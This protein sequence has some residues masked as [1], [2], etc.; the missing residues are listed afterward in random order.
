MLSHL[1]ARRTLAGHR[2][3]AVL[4]GEAIAMAARRDRPLRSDGAGG[5][6]E[7]EEWRMIC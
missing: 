7:E 6:E 3:E 4:A 5:N 2:A 1:W